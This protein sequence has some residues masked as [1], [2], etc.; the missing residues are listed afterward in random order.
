MGGRHLAPF[1]KPLVHAPEMRGLQ[2]KIQFIDQPRDQR[3][4]FGQPN[5]SA[6]ADRIV[7][8]G[9]L[10]SG[11]V[12]EGFGQVEFL[13]RVVKYDAKPGPRQP[14]HL[15][16]GEARGGV[17]DFVV[18]RRVIPP[19]RSDRA[20]LAWHREPLIQ[21]CSS[22]EFSYS[23]FRMQPS[24]IASRNGSRSVALKPRCRRPRKPSAC[25]KRCD[26][27]PTASDISS[28]TPR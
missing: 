6:N 12:F 3:Q 13:E 18:E 16:R 28:I 20:G 14:Q 1:M 26:I 22:K 4:L 17:D 23:S 5:R 24:P 27:S 21:L 15:L 7:G 10:P 25:L 2:R 9:L 11:D 8:G 19:V